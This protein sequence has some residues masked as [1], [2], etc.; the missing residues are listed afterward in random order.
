M[1]A[2]TKSSLLLCTSDQ[3][4]N[5]VYNTLLSACSLSCAF[6]L[7]TPGQQLSLGH[8]VQNKILVKL[9]LRRLVCST[10]LRHLFTSLWPWTKQGT[11]CIH[12][13]LLIFLLRFTN[14]SLQFVFCSLDVLF[15]Y[16]SLYVCY[17]LINLD[18]A[19]VI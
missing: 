14:N 1:H 11:S 2:I 9:L 4:L 12:F 19:E 13:F 10:T 6:D 5:L 15:W 16:V 3:L 17:V 7:L 18:V 8:P